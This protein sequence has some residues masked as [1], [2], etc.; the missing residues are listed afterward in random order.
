MQKFTGNNP[1]LSCNGRQIGCHSA[2]SDQDLT[3]GNALLNGIRNHPAASDSD[4]RWQQRSTNTQGYGAV[5]P[6]IGTSESNYIAFPPD[7]LQLFFIFFCNIKFN[8]N[9][10]E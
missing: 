10:S 7:P 4:T 6:Y 1:C 8:M 3:R 5:F 9:L 2:F